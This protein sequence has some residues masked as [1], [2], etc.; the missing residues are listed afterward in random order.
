MLT[1]VD[2]EGSY[3][4]TNAAFDSTFMSSNDVSASCRMLGA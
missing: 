1:V 4:A 2:D 3:L